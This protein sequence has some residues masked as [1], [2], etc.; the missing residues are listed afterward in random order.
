MT[1]VVGA[2]EVNGAE[3][4]RT[5]SATENIDNLRII[6]G[7]SSEW[8]RCV[9]G[10]KPIPRGRAARVDRP[11]PISYYRT[12]LRLDAPAF[13]PGSGRSW[14]GPHASNKNPYEGRLVP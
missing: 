4:K 12:D 9:L 8:V 1:H 14:P 13:P 6:P 10:G 3:T 11:P 7:A 2:A 5:A